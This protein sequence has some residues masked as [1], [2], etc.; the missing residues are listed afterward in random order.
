[1]MNVR[2]QKQ[3]IIGIQ[4]LVII[5]NAPRLEVTRSQMPPV[6]EPSEAAP[7][8]NF[9]EFLPVP[10][11]TVPGANQHLFLCRPEVRARLQSSLFYI[12]RE[13]WAERFLDP[14]LCQ[15]HLLTKQAAQGRRHCHRYWRQIHPLILTAVRPNR[16]LPLGQHR[17]QLRRMVVRSQRAL[18]LA[19]A[20]RHLP[21]R[22]IVPLI[23]SDAMLC[24]SGSLVRTCQHQTYGANDGVSKRIDN[25]SRHQPRH[26]VVRLTV[27]HFAILLWRPQ[28]AA[29]ELQ[30]ESLAVIDPPVVRCL[31]R[32]AAIGSP[33]SQL[34]RG[35]ALLLHCISLGENK[36][37]EPLCVGFGSYPHGPLSARGL[38][39]RR[40]LLFER[41][42]A[43]RHPFQAW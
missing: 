12:I 33:C 1:M 16:R 42:K 40:E 5:R 20:H 24:R 28:I 4:L 21:T 32:L 30:L 9:L 13:L 2:R 11:V 38:C 29:I 34:L 17:A 26:V 3:S 6:D 22:R 36:L 41:C 31:R 39:C 10:P 7:R 18:E 14:A 37:I 27:R 25:I 35:C 23:E 15:F 19:K 43:A 8:L